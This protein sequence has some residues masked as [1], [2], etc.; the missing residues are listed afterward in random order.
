MLLVKR[1][2]TTVLIAQCGTNSVPLGEVTGGNWAV[3]NRRLNLRCPLYLNGAP[4][5]LKQ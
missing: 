4:Q 3:T 2:F 5:S 1:D